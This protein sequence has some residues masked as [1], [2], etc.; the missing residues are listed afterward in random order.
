MNSNN[1]WIQMA[2]KILW[3][4]FEVKYAD[5]FPS[6]IGNIAKR[7]RRA[8]GSLI[9]QSRFQFHNKEHVEQTIEIPYLQYFIGLLGY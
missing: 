5:L 3:D 9:I 4:K 1:R 7:L 6:D 8:F 2:D